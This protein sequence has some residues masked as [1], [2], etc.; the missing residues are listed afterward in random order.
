VEQGAKALP[1]FWNLLPVPRRG[2]A[3][4]RSRR[5]FGCCRPPAHTKA[6]PACAGERAR[7][8]AQLHKDVHTSPSNK[9]TLGRLARTPCTR[10]HSR[11]P[12]RTRTHTGTHSG[13]SQKPTSRPCRVRPPVL[14]CLDGARTRKHAHGD[15]HARTPARLHAPGLCPGAVR[16]GA[17]RRG[18][19]RAGGRAGT[20]AGAAAA[21]RAEEAERGAGSLLA[22]A[23]PAGRGFSSLGADAADLPAAAADHGRQR[24]TVSAGGR[25][26]ARGA[27]RR[28]H[29]L[30]VPVSDLALRLRSPRDLVPHSLLKVSYVVAGRNRRWGYREG[31]DQATA[32]V[33]RLLAQTRLHTR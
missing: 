29:G 15:R 31:K 12:T 18:R 9:H 14:G 4:P 6:A 30:G 2:A 24:D 20:G 32:S 7:T 19:R 13:R 5:T 33:S 16:R 25:P 3:R 22:R 8:H 23:P 27:T 26:G 1:G 17:A 28:R 21:G 11:A 10:I